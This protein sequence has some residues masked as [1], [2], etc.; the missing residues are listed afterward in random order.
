MII[1]AGSFDEGLRDPQKKAQCKWLPVAVLDA[2]S[3]SPSYFLW[4]SVGVGGRFAML[5]WS[6]QRAYH[7][8]TVGAA[9][10]RGVNK[11]RLPNIFTKKIV[12]GGGL[13][14]RP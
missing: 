3:Y 2:G 7:D 14:L 8:R 11:R 4:S 6:S 10:L 12:S 1:A 13:S 9:C 5:L